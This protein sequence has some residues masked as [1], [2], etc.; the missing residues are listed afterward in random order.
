[1]EDENL[2]TLVEKLICRGGE[3]GRENRREILIKFRFRSVIKIPSVGLA[4]E[5]MINKPA[6]RE[7]SSGKAAE[8]FSIF[9]PMLDFT[10]VQASLNKGKVY[11]RSRFDCD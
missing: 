8:Y 9:P 1:M 11:S 7:P 4:P 5:M 2:F 10:L 6:Y 3:E